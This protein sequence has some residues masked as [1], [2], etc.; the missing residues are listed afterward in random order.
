MT[1]I[2]IPGVKSYAS[3]GETYYYLRRTGERVV[4]PDT[5]QPIDPACDLAAFVARVDQMKAALAGLPAVASAKAGTL[6]TLIE[7]WRGHDGLDGRPKRDPSLEWTQLKPATQKSYERVIQPAGGIDRKGNP[8]PGGYLQRA[9]KPRLGAIALV[10]LDRPMIVRI[11]DKVAKKFGFW[12]GNYVVTVL[13]IL[14]KFGLLHGHMEGENPAEDVP[15]LKRPADMPVQHPSWTDPEFET[16]LA[17]ARR[18]GWTGVVRALA[19][20]RFA[21]WPMGDVVNQPLHA[22]QDPRLV[23]VRH[24]AQ[25]PKV[26]SVK[27]PERLAEILRAT[28]PPAGAP[29]LVVN[30]AGEPYTEDGMRTM[31]WRLCT[32]LAKA[33]KVRR[34]L[35]IH[36]LRHSLGKELYDLDLERDARKAMMAHVTDEASMVYER[37]GDRSRKADVAVLA[38]DLKHRRKKT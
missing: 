26:N 6:L 24:K 33:G 9:I 1:T 12:T 17:D 13:R 7:A 27:A 37:D 2:R 35:N 3:K 4:D 8:F 31:V 21:G 22:W 23:Y 18:R 32:E 20:G 34:G 16:M 5:Q 36:G 15:E 10:D 38:V 30:Q 19:L 11:R 29:R 28:A 14:F 25:M